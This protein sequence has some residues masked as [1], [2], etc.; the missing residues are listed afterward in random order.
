MNS[1][2]V[3]QSTFDRL[4]NIHQ[5]VQLEKIKAINKEQLKVQIEQN[6]QLEA[7]NQQ[8]HHKHN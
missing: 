1:I 6:K 2:K 4:I 7:L 3:R 5:S 8:R